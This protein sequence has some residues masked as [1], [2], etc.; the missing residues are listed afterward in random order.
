M[1]LSNTAA[2]VAAVF[3]VGLS[4]P[5]GAYAQSTSGTPISVAPES[6]LDPITMS[7]CGA[8]NGKLSTCGE[9]SNTL[10]GISCYCPQT[11]LDMLVG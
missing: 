1:K 11:V 10:A 5:C 4:L 3:L 7:S 2:V 9:A 6:C 8:F